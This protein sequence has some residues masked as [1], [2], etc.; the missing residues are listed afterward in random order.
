[1]EP[2]C[3]AAD[4]VDSKDASWQATLDINLRAALVGTRLAAQVMSSQRTQ[5]QGP[6]GALVQCLTAIVLYAHGRQYIV[7]VGTGYRTSNAI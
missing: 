1:M 7:T 5:G 3:G 6:G 2:V 4:F